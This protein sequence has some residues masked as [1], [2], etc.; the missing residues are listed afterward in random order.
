MTPD[1]VLAAFALYL[2]AAA[3]MSFA[4]MP[5]ANFVWPRAV[6]YGFYCATAMAAFGAI[7]IWAMGTLMR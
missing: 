5:L 6:L 4:S 7:G 3:W 1:K 2:I